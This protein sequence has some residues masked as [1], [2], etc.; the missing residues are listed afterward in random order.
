MTAIFKKIGGYGN[1]VNNFG[2][3]SFGMLQNIPSTCIHGHQLAHGFF[4]K[5]V[6]F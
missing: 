3:V 5:L 1:K 4:N 2:L 6:N